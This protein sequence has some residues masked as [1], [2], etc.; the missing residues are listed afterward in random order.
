MVH[1]RKIPAA[2]RWL[3]L[4]N[5]LSRSFNLA[6]RDIEEVLKSLLKELLKEL[7]ANAVAIWTVEEKTQFMKIEASAGLDSLYVRYFN[8]TDRVKIG[9][10]V[11]GKVMVQRKTHYVASSKR[12]SLNLPRWSAIDRDAGFSASVVAP[13]FIGTNIVG[14]FEV[15]YRKQKPSFLAGELQFIEITAD[16]VAVTIEN[17]KNYET[18]VRSERNLL[19]QVERLSEL[20][21]TTQSLS[22]SANK[23]IDE[24]LK[25]FN[26]YLEK[27][28]NIKG[29]I[30]FQREESSGILKLATS[31]GVSEQLN[32]YLATHLQRPGPGTLSGLA[33]RDREIKTSSKVFV[34]ERF[35]KPSRI[36]LSIEGRSA[37]IAL[38]LVVRDEAIGVMVALYPKPHVFSQEEIAILDMAARF[39]G[40]TLLNINFFESL[41]S[42]KQKTANIIGSLNEGIILYGNDSKILLLNPKAEELLLVR[43]EDVI[44]RVVTR[45]ISEENIFLKNIY[46]ISNLSLGDND[47]TEYTTEGSERIIL[48]VS[49]VPVYGAGHEKTG[50]MH[51]LR[52]I[53]KEKEIEMLKSKFLVTASHQLRT[54]ISG[55]RWA[56][57]ILEKGEKGALNPAQQELVKKTAMVATDLNDLLNDLLTITKAEE[58]G[59]LYDFKKQDIVPVLEKIIAD[60]ELLSKEYD[61][62]LSFIKPLEPLPPVNVDSN[63]VSQ[64]I[65]N[66]IDNALCYSL[67]KSTVKVSLGVAEDNIVIRVKD[68]GIGI[69]QEDQK[70]IFTKFYRAKNAPAQRTRGSGLGLYLSKNIIERHKGRVTFSS[71]EGEGT[72]FFIYLP[73]A[74]P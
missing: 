57:D 23:S 48:E 49:S 63:A 35:M 19:D 11:V 26:K 60:F 41:V 59:L 3:R 1:Q 56:L 27:R 6:S 62:T 12:N 39:L 17:I 46:N 71:K 52:D 24:P 61:V 8:K 38:P 18:I 73:T 37:M 54:P 65:R 28:F 4:V 51:T 47:K 22:L 32:D 33:F 9:Q 29:L 14:A 58:E 15:F 64:A 5:N 34:D 25:V 44:G 74:T 69:S 68:S 2:P 66:V 67:S 13:M 21:K 36:M 42:E 45:E 10:G 20:Q 70:F 16:Q 50:F 30:I 72:E 55:L 31:L 7:G 53:T 40:V 43:T